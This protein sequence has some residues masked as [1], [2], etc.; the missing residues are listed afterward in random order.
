MQ[1]AAVYARYGW[2]VIPLHDVTRG[3][4]SCGKPNCPSAGKHPRVKEWQRAASRDPATIAQWSAH[5][6]DANVGIATGAS[7]GFF[8]LDVD[9]DNGGPASLARL[10][11][12]HGAL[13]LTA[14]QRTGSGGTHYLFQIPDF[15]VTNSAGKLGKG[16]D[17]RGDNGQIVVAP[18]ISSKGTYSWVHLPWKVGIAPAPAWLLALLRKPAARAVN[19]DPDP[20]FPPASLE[21]LEGARLALAEHGPAVSG[22]GGDAHTFIAGAILRHD[23]ALTELEAWPLLLEWNDTCE[24]PW[25]EDDLAAKM[26]GGA[27]YATKAYGCLRHVDALAAAQKVISDWRVAGKSE[28]AIARMVEECR[29]IVRR[30]VDPTIRAQIQHALEAATEL[31]A[32]E[33]ALPPAVDAAKLA[34]R[35]ERRDALEAGDSDLI[36]SKD[37]LGTAKRFLAASADVDGLPELVRWQEA[38]WRAE[39]TRY[40]E[41][42]GEEINSDLYDF[43][44]G[45]REVASN[46]PLKP[47]RNLVETIVHALRAAALLDVKSA[48]AWIDGPREHSAEE[49]LAFKNGLLHTPTRAWIPATRAF[50]GLN[51][52]GFDYDESAPRNLSTRM[53]QRLSQFRL[54]LVRAP[55]PPA[56]R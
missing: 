36:D 51:A 34:E 13:P 22:A 47:D 26:R 20:T 21:E 9:P 23:F 45:K 33:V 24:P 16:L 38:F 37:P 50:F 31:K 2:P 53:R 52:V 30:G 25:S 44:E 49:I 35:K 19:T 27:K 5:R 18:S 17:T 6:T 28:L 10:V 46:A 48:P 39:G 42:G 40:A 55:P 1:A 3:S 41:R 43:T 29:E 56:S 32:R 12:E 8:V 11:A 15:S 4:C 54:Q 14:E 7:A